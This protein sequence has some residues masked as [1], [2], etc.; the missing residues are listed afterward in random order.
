VKY[1][2]NVIFKFLFSPVNIIPP[3]LHTYLHLN[4]V[5]T[6]RTKQQRPGNVQMKLLGSIGQKSTFMFQTP[7][8]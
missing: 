3:M 5:L 4:A 7:K 1:R 6:R 2:L 8:R